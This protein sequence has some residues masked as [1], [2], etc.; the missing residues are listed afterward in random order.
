VNAGAVFM[1]NLNNLSIVAFLVFILSAC[2][3]VPTQVAKKTEIIKSNYGHLSSLEKSHLT[4]AFLINHDPTQTYDVCLSENM[5]ENFPGIEQ[6][7]K[8]SI[9][10]WGYYIG[11]KIDVNIIK[12]PLPTADS[13]WT[14]NNKHE[15]YRQRC[16]RGVDLIVGEDME[17][18]GSIAYTHSKSDPIWDGEKWVARSFSRILMLRT[19]NAEGVR[20]NKF[21]T[22]KEITG[23]DHSEEEILTVLK[24]R[25]T[26][27][28]SPGWNKVPAIGT[29]IHEVGHIWGLCDMYHL[30]SG[31]NCDPNHS[32][33]RGVRGVAVEKESVMY[34]SLSVFPFFLR[35]DDINGIKTLDSRFNN[36]PRV[37]YTNIERPLEIPEEQNAYWSELVRLNEATITE[38]HIETRIDIETNGGKEL[39]LQYKYSEGSTWQTTE[40]YNLFDQ[41]RFSNYL[42]KFKYKTFLKEAY[43]IRVVLISTDSLEEPIELLKGNPDGTL[44]KKTHKPSEIFTRESLLALKQKPE[45]VEERKPEEEVRPEQDSGTIEIVIIEDEEINEETTVESEGKEDESAPKEESDSDSEEKEE[46]ESGDEES[47]RG[48][49]SDGEK[50]D[51]TLPPATL[52]D[53]PTLPPATLDDEPTLPPATLDNEPT[54]PP[55]TLDNEPTLPPA[56][57]DDEPTLPP[58]TLDDEPTLPPAT[59]DDEPSIRVPKEN[60]NET[61]EKSPST[62]KREI[63]LGDIILDN[64]A[65]GSSTSGNETEGTETETS[66]ARPK[67]NPGNEPSEA[68]PN[69]ENNENKESEKENVIDLMKILQSLK[70]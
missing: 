70:K 30:E 12:R 50:D 22:L 59:L 69:A 9:N 23:Q 65:E 8:A 29:I 40:R 19:I 41:A 3:E 14:V 56:T 49:E 44:N 20:N 42:F 25:N 62:G 10:I 27:L 38:T 58:A 51:P 47:D 1:L 52:D 55:A 36:D 48:G 11:R 16:P 64:P 43:E 6:E 31:S 61:E 35:D 18:T 26:K 21:V 13:S 28:F 45:P 4:P 67:P 60:D 17:S 66:K 34:S 5:A 54:L 53:K 15:V 33:H 32:E 63:T 68:K 24:K 37:K 2:Q 46:D 7:I 39:A 57:L